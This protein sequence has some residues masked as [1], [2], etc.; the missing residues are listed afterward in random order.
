[1]SPEGWPNRETAHR[2][3]PRS[4][5]LQPKQHSRFVVSQHAY[6]SGGPHVKNR[7]STPQS[8][9][10][11]LSEIKKVKTLNLAT[12]FGGCRDARKVRKSKKRP[13]LASRVPYAPRLH[14]SEVQH[15]FSRKSIFS[16]KI[17]IVAR[18]RA[19]RALARNTYRGPMHWHPSPPP[20]CAVPLPAG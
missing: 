1:M 12:K 7:R 14:Y 8:Q 20:R 6:K 9:S 15:F 16:P 11:L 4:Q 2:A 18:L 5:H 17:G 19:Q 10:A 3:V 13:S